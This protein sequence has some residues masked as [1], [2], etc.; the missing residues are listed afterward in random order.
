[1]ASPAHRPSVF[2]FGQFELDAAN[3]ELRKGGVSLKLHPQPFQVLLL[4]VERPRQIVTRDEIRGCL[5]GGNTFV[6]FERGINSCVNQIRAT[7]GDDPEKP[8]YV[9]TLPRRGYRFIAAV[10]NGASQQRA[11][12]VPLAVLPECDNG[13]RPTV[14]TSGIPFVLTPSA[15]NTRRRWKT[16][17]AIAAFVFL[18]GLVIATIFYF[19]PPAKLTGIHSIILAD[20]TNATGDQVFDNTLRQGLSI[21]LEQSP[22]LS[23]V[24]EQQIQ[25]TL[26]MM[27]RKPDGKFTQEI[28]REVCQRR[29]SAAVLDGSIAQIGTQYLLTLKAVNCVS[30]ESL[31]S[32]EA[33]AGDKNHVLDALGKTASHIRT[34]LGESLSTVQKFDTPLEQATTSSLE[35]LQAYSLGWKTMV[36]DGEYDASAPLFERAIRLDPNFAMA[37]AALGVALSAHAELRE[38][39]T[40]K[41]YELR[42]R[43]SERERFYIESHY[44]HLVIG[45]IE[46]ARQV[47]ELWALTY[48]R[49]WVP[50]NNL[51][52]LCHVLGQYEK[53]L[54]AGRSALRV[55]PASSV[56]YHNV[57]SDLIALNRLDEARVMAEHPPREKLD[58]ASQILLYTLDFLQNDELGMQR[59]VA[60]ASGRP[61]VEGEILNLEAYSQAYSG[62]M[63]HARELF[64]RA[65]NSALRSNQNETAAGYEAALA[66]IE[67]D[68]GN[69]ERSRQD[70][71]AALA[72]AQ[73]HDVQEVVAV[74]MARAGDSA[75]AENMTEQFVKQIPQ[76]IYCIY[77]PRIRSAI[78][79]NRSN[80]SKAIE[81]LQTASP[82]E[83]GSID[84]LYSAYLRGLGFLLLRQSSEAVAEFQKISDHRGIVV[85]QPTGALARLGLARAYLLQGDTAKAHA[86]YQDFLTLWKDADPDI[87]ILIAAKA[88]Y[89]K[90]K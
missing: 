58:P 5:W 23:L 63:G 79:I 14:H 74:A 87:P 35:A 61:E 15:G 88:E 7:L 54:E 41:A 64:R 24:S 29:G 53:A 73:T 55:D 69:S 89:A 67:A 9:E 39:N 22:F 36:G 68:Y 30:G 76:I 90:L 12:L 81:L 33:Q 28:A 80:P 49:D 8:R 47:Y 71:A 75:R 20:F 18:G 60:W 31:A 16:K 78:D 4:L 3:G 10:T 38:Q 27:G 77:V 59:Q 21:Q 25:Q 37:Y 52:N 1:M 56:S 11:N 85:N 2:C 48:P 43:V 6:D 45:D 82:Y 13:S 72:L 44:Y 84:T 83:L 42:E 51:G 62:K 50:L 65:V 66:W 86:A 32:T 17:A 70:V 40:K 46:K 57:V 19:R 26:Q 34:K